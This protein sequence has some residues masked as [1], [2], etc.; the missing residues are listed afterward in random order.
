MEEKQEQVLEQKE[1]TGENK[2]KKNK[3]KDPLERL[4]TKEQ[5]DVIEKNFRKSAL[6]L[7]IMNILI[8]IEIVLSILAVIVIKNAAVE[9][10]KI[11][12]IVVLSAVGAGILAMFTVVMLLYFSLKKYL[13]SINVDY[14]E[15]KK[16]LKG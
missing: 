10:V 12:F 13:K 7:K 15:F 6:F 4:I 8:I 1:N 16:A 14:K 9:W 2:E 3:K 5:G 11:V